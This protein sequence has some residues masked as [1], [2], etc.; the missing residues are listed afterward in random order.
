MEF[1]N[2]FVD[3]YQDLSKV[4]NL[5]VSKGIFCFSSAILLYKMKSLFFSLWKL[6]KFFMSLLKAQVSFPSN[7]ASIFITPPYFYSSNIIYN[8]LK[9]SLLKCK[10]L[11]FSSTRVKICQVS[12]VNFELESQFFFKFCI[13]LHCH[14]K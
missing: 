9:S 2:T 4:K 8:L 1:Y 3:R 11:R 12:Y 6:A 14:D 10:L 7:F 13:I 5:A